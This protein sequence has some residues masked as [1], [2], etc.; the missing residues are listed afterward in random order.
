MFESKS[1]FIFKSREEAEKVLECMRDIVDKFGN[2]SVRDF[3]DLL[4]FPSTKN[5]RNKGWVLL[6]NFE[7]LQKENE[8]WM[9]IPPVESI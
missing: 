2:V 3:Y 9:Y 4:G 7:I 8:Y 5:S 6:T 1:Y